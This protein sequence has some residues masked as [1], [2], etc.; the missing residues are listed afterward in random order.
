MI[1]IPHQA[2]E[3]HHRRTKHGN[4]HD[5]MTGP[6]QIK[7]PPPPELGKLGRIGQRARRVQGQHGEEMVETDALVC[8]APAVE[9]DAVHDRGQGREDEEGE[10]GGAEA[11]GGGGEAAEG[12]AQD[13]DEEEGGA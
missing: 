3:M 5:L 12:P 11:V 13:E 4:M 2:Q 10:E 7:A 8:G 9:D 6:P 1:I